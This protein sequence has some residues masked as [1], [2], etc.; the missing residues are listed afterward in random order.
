MLFTYRNYG[1]LLD[2]AE[3]NRL[4]FDQGCKRGRV[5]LHGLLGQTIEQFAARRRGATVESKSEL[6][7]VIVQMS[8]CNRAPMSAEQPSLRLLNVPIILAQSR[9]CN[10]VANISSASEIHVTFCPSLVTMPNRTLMIW[11]TVIIRPKLSDF[12]LPRM[13]FRSFNSWWNPSNPPKC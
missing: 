11:V 1:Y 9:L 5:C 7:E 2:A 8:V 12:Q 3:R 6:V 4:W 10:S 13:M